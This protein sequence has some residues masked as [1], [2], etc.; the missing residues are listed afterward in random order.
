VAQQRLQE[1]EPALVEP[2]ALRNTEAPLPSTRKL[3]VRVIAI[4]ILA[5]ASLGLV[6]AEL[7]RLLAGK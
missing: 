1:I 6:A 4:W 3:W 7:I 2:G 5:S